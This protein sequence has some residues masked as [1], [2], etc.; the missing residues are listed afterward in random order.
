[1]SVHPQP[2]QAADGVLVGFNVED[3]GVLIGFV[4]QPDA[5]R[6]QYHRTQ[7]NAEGD[8]P[9]SA[10]CQFLSSDIYHV[11]EDEDDH[12]DHDGDAQSALSDDGAQWG[13]DEEEDDACQREREFLVAFQ[14]MNAQRTVGAE[15]HVAV[16]VRLLGTVACLVQS[17]TSYMSPLVIGEVC[18]DGV[19]VQR[20]RLVVLCQHRG[21]SASAQPCLSQE[22]VLIVFVLLAPCGIQQR[23]DGVYTHIQHRQVLRLCVVVEEVGIHDAEIVV[24]WNQVHLPLEGLAHIGYSGLVQRTASVLHIAETLAVIERQ[25]EMHLVG[26]GL[27][28][29]GVCQH[30]LGVVEVCALRVDHNA[31]EHTCLLVLVLHKEIVARNLVVELSL[32]NFHFRRFLAH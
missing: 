15:A 32:G 14:L 2:Q 13:S 19:E 21:V 25:T 8:V 3:G 24:E 6:C 20:M 12:R 4:G 16:E 30:N 28:A 9:V 17:H 26:C 1:M 22:T 23:R 7:P 31:I 29:A 10:L 11:V 5:N 18:E 27:D